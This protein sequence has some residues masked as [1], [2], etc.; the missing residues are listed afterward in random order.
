MKTR[1]VYHYKCDGGIVPSH[2]HPRNVAIY[3]E[4]GKFQVKL[5]GNKYDTLEEAESELMDTYD[6]ITHTGTNVSK[7][8]E[9]DRVL[10]WENPKGSYVEG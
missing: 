10:K 6:R 2:H 5:N 9:R 8:Q 1:T 3:H 7:F 4:N